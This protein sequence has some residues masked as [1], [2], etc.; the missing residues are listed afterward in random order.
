MVI[1]NRTKQVIGLLFLLAGG[2]VAICKSTYFVMVKPNVLRKVSTQEVGL[3][4]QLMFQFAGPFHHVC[5]VEGNV[6]TISFPQ[7]QLDGV[8]AASIAKRLSALPLVEQAQ[9][10]ES[11]QGLHCVIA[12]V[13]NHVLLTAPHKVGY[14]RL[15]CE[16]YAQ[17]DFQKIK[18]AHDGPLFH[19]QEQVDALSEI[20]RYC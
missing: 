2:S 10:K 4:R 8:K 20:T 1:K 9:C 12:F 5:Q 16:V 14:D 6:L 7:A 3:A 18:D 13:P 15:V 17:N 11:K 19:A